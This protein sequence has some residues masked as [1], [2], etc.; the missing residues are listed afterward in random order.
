M[1]LDVR[2]VQ[3]PSAN[4]RARAHLTAS[5]KFDISDKH[6]WCMLSSGINKDIACIR[7]SC[8]DHPLLLFY[9]YSTSLVIIENKRGNSLSDRPHQAILDYLIRLIN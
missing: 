5:Y 9:F 4:R 3:R 2:E 8:L 7:K 1:R 6:S